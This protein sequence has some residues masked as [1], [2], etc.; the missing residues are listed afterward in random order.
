[1][2]AKPEEGAQLVRFGPAGVPASC[3][4]G[5]LEGVK[6]ASELGLRAMELEFVR[7]AKMG[8]DLAR[9]VGERARSLDVRLSAHGPYYINLLSEKPETRKASVERILQTAR[10]VHAAGGGRIA[11]HAAYY[12]KHTPEQATKELKGIHKEIL[13]KMAKENLTTAILAPETSGGKAE[14]GGLE[15]I[16]EL[17]S[18]F[19]LKRVN[20]TIDFSHLH[21][22]PGKGW[23]YKKEDYASVFER[24]EKALG[25]KAV[26]SFHSHFQSI[27]YTD[28]GEHHHLT[29]DHNE[30]PFKPLAELLAEQGYSGTIISE[31]PNIEADALEMQR[32]YRRA[33]KR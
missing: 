15:E 5:S 27:A 28:R 9:Q 17:C 25:K 29:I 19:D 10:I 14:W 23:L 24:L 1:M 13:E 4:G 7:G 18:E 6:C 31:S 2:H 8:L 26:E 33:L 32:E 16:L 20:P 22:R 30:P 3:S 11:Y 21:A 12:G